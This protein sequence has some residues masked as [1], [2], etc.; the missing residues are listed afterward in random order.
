MIFP[1]TRYALIACRYLAVAYNENRYVTAHE[2]ADRYQMDVRM[3]MLALNR[4]IRADILRSRVGDAEP[5]FIFCCDPQEIRMVDVITAL[6]G[7]HRFVCCREVISGIQCDCKDVSECQIYCLM[8]R[9]ILTAMAK[10]TKLSLA[11][12]CEPNRKEA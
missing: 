12:Y 9:T 7:K 5:G 10:L 1:S 3:L 2:I 4:L 11:D 6:E 8:N